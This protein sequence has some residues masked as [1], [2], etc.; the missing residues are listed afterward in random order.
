[1]NHFLK[2]LFYKSVFT[3]TRVWVDKRASRS[4]ERK[5]VGIGG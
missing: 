3:I 1:M 2:I 4:L 5:G